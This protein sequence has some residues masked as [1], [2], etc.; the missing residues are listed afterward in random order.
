[1]AASSASGCARPRAPRESAK[2]VI[3]GGE[4]GRRGVLDARVRK[5]LDGD[6][7]RAAERLA[8]WQGE[9]VCTD[10]W[11]DVGARLAGEREHSL[12]QLRCARK[13]PVARRG[14]RGVVHV[15][16]EDACGEDG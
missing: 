15:G 4:T 3:N 5:A 6:D 9:R 11:T 14:A 10:A 12:L 2:Q 1:M 16:Q 13:L 8:G 7:A